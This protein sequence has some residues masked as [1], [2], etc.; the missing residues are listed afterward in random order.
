MAA[1]PGRFGEFRDGVARAVDYA[2]LLKPACVHMM[3]GK[4]EPA[5]PVARDSYRRA[6]RYAAEALAPLD[7]T[8]T[9]EPINTRDVPGYYLRDFGMAAALVES[10]GLLNVGFQFDI[11]HC[12]IIHGDVTTMLR[13]LL[14]ITR[15][16][17]VASVPSRNE[18]DGEELNFPFLFEE[19][20]R[21]GYEG[22]V[23]GEYTPRGATVDGLGW[24]GL[25]RR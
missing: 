13:Q 18:P 15:H 10:A 6:V 1:D 4:A 2:G 5:N 12:Q 14:P 17:Q 8:L 19:L 7:V 25:P 22:V 24:A 9:L 21:L 16:I 23:A 20:D 3:S 11:Y